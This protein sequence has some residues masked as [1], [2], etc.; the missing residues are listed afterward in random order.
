MMSNLHL[1]DWQQP[2]RLPSGGALPCSVLFYGWD[3]SQASPHSVTTW[4][5]HRCYIPGQNRAPETESACHG[6][7][8][9][10]LSLGSCLYPSQTSSR[11]SSDVK[12]VIPGLPWGSS[13]EESTFQ[14]PRV[15][16]LVWE[17]SSHTPWAN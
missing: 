2:W 11:S 16:S 8:S 3:V 5:A 6:L 7:W 17:V 12:G 13:G 4:N 9:A 15:C 1:M 14:E 10:F